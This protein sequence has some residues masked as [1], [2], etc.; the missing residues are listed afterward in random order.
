MEFIIS[1]LSTIIVSTVLLLAVAVIIIFRVR[2]RKKGKKC[3]GCTA[4]CCPNRC[5]KDL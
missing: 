5:K 2:A 1:N 4:D 3:M